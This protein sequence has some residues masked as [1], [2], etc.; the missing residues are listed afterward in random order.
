[1]CAASQA[2]LAAAQNH[3]ALRYVFSPRVLRR[4]LLIALLVGCFLSAVNHFEALRA[5]VSARLLL[6]VLV[7][8]AVPFVVST[9]SAALNRP[10]M[11]TE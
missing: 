3:S 10:R 2:A 6:K 1:M 9:T 7:N 5:P 4:S 11:S 8:F